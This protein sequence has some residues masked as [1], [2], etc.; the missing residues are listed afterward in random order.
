MKLFAITRELSSNELA[1][2]L[3]NIIPRTSR[4]IIEVE[5]NTHITGIHTIIKQAA[6]QIEKITGKVAHYDN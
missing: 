1:F 5:V 2:S 3:F 4:N 6:E